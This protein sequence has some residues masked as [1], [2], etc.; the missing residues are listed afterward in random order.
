MN[1]EG[2]AHPKSSSKIYF[3]EYLRQERSDSGRPLQ[4]YPIF[5]RASPRLGLGGMSLACALFETK[6]ASFYL[7]YLFAK[8]MTLLNEKND[9]Q[10]LTKRSAL[11]SF[12]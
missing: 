5:G 1:Y 6:Q 8:I 4:N 9:K 11:S 12:L 10:Q 3:I 7:S 2:K